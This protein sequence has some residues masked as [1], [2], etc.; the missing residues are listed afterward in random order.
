[1]YQQYDSAVRAVLDSFDKNGMSK[2]VRKYFRHDVKALKEYLERKGLE[3]SCP[4][5]QAWLDT[6]KPSL[7][8]IAYLSFRRSIALIEEA[9]RH[10]EVRTWYFDY[11]GGGPRCRVTDC[12]RRLL[13][14]YLARRAREGC[15]PSTLQ[16]DAIACTRFLLFLQSRG[17]DDPALH[18]ARDH[19]SLPCA[20][21]AS[22]PRGQECLHLSD[23]EASSGSSPNAALSRKPLS[24]PSRPRRRHGCGSSVSCRPRRSPQFG[25][26]ALEASPCRNFEALPWRRSL[27]GWACAPSTSAGCG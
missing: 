19:Q 25:R 21:Q 13:D 12:P 15:Q 9:V 14:E 18:N 16:M 10:G 24:A 1:M 17:I 7:T 20:G 2:T 4:V 6:A 27:F 22:D 3:Y 11:K 5:A 8:R 23:T 26:T